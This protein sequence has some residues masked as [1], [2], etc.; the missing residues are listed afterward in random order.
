MTRDHQDQD[1]RS[2]TVLFAKTSI[3]FPNLPRQLPEVDLFL[4]QD[5]LV[6]AL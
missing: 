2:P 3:A 1:K 4:N 5:R 6:G